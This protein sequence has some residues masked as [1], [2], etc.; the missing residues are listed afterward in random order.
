[1]GCSTFGQIAGML[2]NGLRLFSTACNGDQTARHYKLMP[3]LAM[4]E[5]GHS[6]VPVTGSWRDPVLMS[7]EI[8]K[9]ELEILVAATDDVEPG[10]VVRPSD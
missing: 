3:P 8:F 9:A 1:M 6:W 2:S 4:A 10:F 7:E 5:G